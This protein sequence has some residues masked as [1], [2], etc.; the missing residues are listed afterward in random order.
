MMQQNKKIFV[1][2]MRR[3]SSSSSL[4][5]SFLPLHLR[6]HI[7][8]LVP[9]AGNRARL[10][11]VNRGWLASTSLTPN[12]SFRGFHDTARAE[13]LGKAVREIQR[14]A[15]HGGPSRHL[16][17]LLI[18]HGYHSGPQNTLTKVFTSAPSAHPQY[19]TVTHTAKVT[20]VPGTSWALRFHSQTTP[21]GRRTR[22]YYLA[23]VESHGADQRSMTI[24]DEDDR[25]FG[26]EITSA[27]GRIGIVPF[28][29]APQQQQH[30]N[31]EQH[32][33]GYQGA[34]AH[35]YL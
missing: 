18:S 31:E 10:R 22:E 20:F 23:R 14:W 16:R 30:F 25:E 13:T 11:A 15:A 1:M 5:S 29:Y 26:A 35:L 3:S 24:W 7:S 4:S 2:V 21:P 9:D 34:G 33:G 28:V 19:G 32:F 8:S 6:R 27:L 12:E 17:R